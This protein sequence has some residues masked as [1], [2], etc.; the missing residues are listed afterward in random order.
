MT[1][2]HSLEDARLDRVFHAPAD[3]RRRKIL[4]RLSRG[5]ATVKQLAAPL[6]M[7]LPSAVKHLAL[8]EDTGLV[9]SNKVG[10]GRTYHM[11]ANAFEDVES[12][13]RARKARW[14]RHV[15]RLERYLA[16]TPGQASA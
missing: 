9:A 7:G 15:D 11:P 1:Q 8:L 14:N 12:W 13:V 3:G 5:P 16:T 2:A 10:R 4:D 6:A